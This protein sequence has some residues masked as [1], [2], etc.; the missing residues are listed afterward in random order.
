MQKLTLKKQRNEY[1]KNQIEM[2]CLKLQGAI[3][4]LERNLQVLKD[5]SASN[6]AFLVQKY[7]ESEAVS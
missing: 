5:E 1:R 7:C 2:N 6:L 3:K 4:E